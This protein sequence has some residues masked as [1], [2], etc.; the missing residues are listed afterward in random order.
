[1]V[2]RVAGVQALVPP[3]HLLGSL[4]RSAQVDAL[5]QWMDTTIAANRLEAVF[6]CADTLIYG[7]LINSRRCADTY[8]Q[9]QQRLNALTGWKKKLGNVPIYIQSS[10]MRISDNHDATEEKDYWSRYGREIF[11]WSENLHRLNSNGSIAAGVLRESE[12]RVPESIRQDYLQT[13]YRNFHINLDILE[14]LS[15]GFFSRVVLNLD[16]SGEYGLNV[17]EK[18]KLEKRILQLNLSETASCYAGADE[19]ICSMIAHWLTTRNREERTSANVI[20]SLPAAEF[21]QSRYEGQS[22]GNSIRAQLK[23]AGVRQLDL[24]AQDRLEPDF[25]VIVHSGENGQGDHILL[26][27]HQDTRTIDTRD[28][29][30]ATITALRAATR[31]CVLCDVAYA[32]G[33]DPQLVAQLL[34]QPE[35]LNKLWAYS[36]WNTTGNTVGSALA[37]AVARHHTIDQIAAEDATKEALFIRLADD[38]AYQTQVRSQL[39]GPANQE[40]ERHISPL[41]KDLTEALRFHKSGCIMSFPWNRLF[42]VEITLPVGRDVQFS[43]A[44]SSKSE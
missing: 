38:W 36:G 39:T 28:A 15:K 32:N 5:H 21:C 1:M 25:T 42:E 10:I 43:G 9:A 16:D 19:V 8:K 31:P 14:S 18:E 6:I 27:G 24:E 20:Y 11:A 23:A 3:R 13:R 35:L 7:G 44:A 30:S 40:L 22:I 12:M 26:P 37:L 2:A 4:N 29:V 17:L 34:K 41:I 33:A